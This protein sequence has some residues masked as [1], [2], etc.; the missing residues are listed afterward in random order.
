MC[1]SRARTS[2]PTPRSVR[3]SL[4]GVATLA[5]LASACGTSA[6]A[7]S[8]TVADSPL[9]DLFGWG[10]YDPVQDKA[11]ELKIQ[12]LTVAC[13]ADEGF[14]YQPETYDQGADANAVEDD[15]DLR[16]DPIAFGEKYGYGTVHDYETWEIEQIQAQIDGE[17][18]PGDTYIDPNQDY[19]ESL[20]ESEVNVYYET[21]YGKSQEW[22]VDDDGNDIQPPALPPEDRGCMSNARTEVTGPDPYNEP[23]FAER[24]NDYW[25]NR[26]DD[27]RLAAANADWAECMADTISTFDPIDGFTIDKPDD[28]WTRMSIDKAVLTGQWV[29]TEDPDSSDEFDTEFGWGSQETSDGSQIAWGGKQH[30]IEPDQLEG[31]RAREIEVWKQDWDCQKQSGTNDVRIDVEQELADNLAADFPG[32]VEKS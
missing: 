6:D 1:D 10:D 14:E 11:N 5:F 24:M 26:N 2:R 9:A 30:L 16:S 17:Q 21:L 25:E 18:A 32:L 8:A 22:Q 13:M 23:E 12:E 7:E 3:R 27:P 31:F 28:M 20:S 4:V 19:I 15:V 29:T